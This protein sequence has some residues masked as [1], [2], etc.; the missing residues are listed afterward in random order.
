[1]TLEVY[2]QEFGECGDIAEIGCVIC[3]ANV[4]G[5]QHVCVKSILVLHPSDGG[6]HRLVAC[7]IV[8]P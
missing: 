5:V 2:T 8:L 7:T 6:A 3:G 4:T 1:V